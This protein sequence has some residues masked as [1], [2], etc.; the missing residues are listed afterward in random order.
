[1]LRPQALELWGGTKLLWGFMKWG[2]QAGLGTSSRGCEK[3][4]PVLDRVLLL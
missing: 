2:S 1:V 3:D 4:R